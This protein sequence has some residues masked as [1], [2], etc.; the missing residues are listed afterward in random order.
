MN[1]PIGECCALK[2]MFPRNGFRVVVV[3]EGVDW[4]GT[5]NLTVKSRFRV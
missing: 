1:A 2:L 3:V 4:F 5:S